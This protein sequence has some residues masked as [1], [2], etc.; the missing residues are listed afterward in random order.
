[1]EVEEDIAVIEESLIAFS[2]E[3]DVHIKQEEIWEDK[4]FADLKTE[5]DQVS[6]V[7]ICV[8]LLFIIC[9]QPLQMFWQETEPSQAT[10]MALARCICRQVLKGSLLLL[11]TAFRCSH[12]H[13]QMP[14]CPHQ[15]KRS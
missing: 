5:P 2:E 13:H 9:I 15:C 10:G 6:Y 12:F 8:L 14:P 11:S 4:T 3:A 1:M 7:R